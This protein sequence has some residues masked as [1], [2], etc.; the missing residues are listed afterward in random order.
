VL[1]TADDPLGYVGIPA[2][3][4]PSAGIAIVDDTVNGVAR[5]RHGG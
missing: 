1:E 5:A 3:I 4:R 2:W